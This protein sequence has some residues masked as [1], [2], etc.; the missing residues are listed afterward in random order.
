LSVV[1][2]DCAACIGVEVK[3]SVLGDQS[4]AILTSRLSALLSQMKP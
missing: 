1:A 2:D 4:R 3:R